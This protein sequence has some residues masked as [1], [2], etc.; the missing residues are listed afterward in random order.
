MPI[1]LTKV[2]TREISF[3]K[4][5]QKALWRSAEKWLKIFNYADGPSLWDWD[6]AAKENCACCDLDTTR[7]EADGWCQ[8]TCSYCPIFKYTGRANCFGTPYQS[9]M[10]YA[11]SKESRKEWS[12]RMYTFLVCLAL[13]E[14]PSPNNYDD[15]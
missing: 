4:R 13:G 2:I 1:K 12:A 5:D 7:G 6:Q 9:C 3:N 15:L 11:V 10:E 8:S 14:N